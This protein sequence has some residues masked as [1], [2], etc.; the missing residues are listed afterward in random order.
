MDS[1]QRSSSVQ[2]SPQPARRTGVLL[3]A[4]LLGTPLAAGILA[5]IM[6][7][8]FKDT[9][10][11]RYVSH[12]VEQV[13][14][15]LFCGAIGAFATK[16]WRTLGEK[17]ACRRELLTPWD[18]KPIDPMEAHGLMAA[19]RRLP[20]RVQNSMVGMRAAAI[21]DFLCRR[22]SAAELDDQLRTL[23]DNDVVATENS[24]ALT[25]FITWA[26]PILGFLGTVLGITGAISG[27]TPEKLEHDLNSVTDGLA[28]AFDA[29]ALALAL[30]M[31]AMFCSFIVERAEQ[32]VLDAVDQFVDRE[33][34][35]RF[36][37][38]LPG[39]NG[40]LETVQQQTRIMVDAVD[41]LVQRQAE[42]WRESMAAA[43][44]RSQL[45]AGE[46]MER[47]TQALDGVLTKT[48]A[49]H[50]E[51]VRQLEE[52]ANSRAVAL[53]GQHDKLSA[54]MQRAL[55]EQ[56][57]SWSKIQECLS[58]QV[59]SMARLQETGGSLGKIQ[60]TLNA[61][62][63]ALAETGSFEEALHSLTAAIHLMTARAGQAGPA[64][65]N[66]GPR[67]AA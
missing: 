8:P 38:G 10:I 67:A 35:H 22:G 6:Y 53:A 66:I 29:T 40:V 63:A 1:A 16:L 61:N 20:R 32:G 9:E 37:H 65:P 58:S 30:T 47:L 39:G 11:P 48:S 24:Y 17:R 43:E 3:P 55:R 34:A 59:Q 44:D 60:E 5:F 7:G 50:V 21:L 14:I 13:E 19:L 57:A 2:R 27:V 23:S 41:R 4:I 18:G 46:Q 15:L 33:L 64:R 45:V 56:H 52:Q 54:E 12:R 49:S 28:L 36:E 42:L 51:R 26:I 31:I 25:R 62:L